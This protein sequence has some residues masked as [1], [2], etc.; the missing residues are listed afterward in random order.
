VLLRSDRPAPRPMRVQR[1]TAPG[2]CAAGPWERRYGRRRASGTPTEPAPARVIRQRSSRSHPATGRPARRCG[3]RAERPPA[4]TRRE[5]DPGSSGETCGT[6]GGDQPS[7]WDAGSGPRPLARRSGPR[8]IGWGRQPATGA[9]PRSAGQVPGGCACRQEQAGRAAARCRA[10][11]SRTRWTFRRR[12]PGA[13]R[14]GRCWHSRGVSSSCSPFRASP[15]PLWQFSARPP[16]R[17]PS[18]GSGCAR[19]CGWGWSSGSPSSSRSCRGP[20]STSGPSPGS[21][22]P[23]GRPCTSPSSAVPPR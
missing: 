3:M 16:W 4:P 15:C 20:A 8:P 6:S 11:R 18:T 21:P 17:W 7:G 9:R 13:G 14:G 1:L 19:A 2:R 12:V 23:S 10:P 22:W 5:D